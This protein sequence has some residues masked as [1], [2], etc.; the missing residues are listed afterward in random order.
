[1]LPRVAVWCRSFPHGPASQRQVT[2]SPDSVL[3]RV[4]KALEG[5][6]RRPA[7]GAASQ[8][9]EHGPSVGHCDGS[10]DHDGRARAILRGADVLP[11]ACQ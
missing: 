5:C 2:T 8:A 6:E 9:G 7:G 1:V 4:C 3:H 11:V 10:N